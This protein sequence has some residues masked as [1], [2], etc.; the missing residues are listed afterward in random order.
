MYRKGYLLIKTA[1]LGSFFE[2]HI[3]SRTQLLANT[4]SAD[5]VARQMEPV[6]TER[7]P[8]SWL[9]PAPPSRVRSAGPGPPELASPAKGN[10]ASSNAPLRSTTP[11]PSLSAGRPS[12]R[13]VPRPPLSGDDSASNLSNSSPR[14]RPSP[15]SHT[16]FTHHSAPQRSS[17]NSPARNGPKTTPPP[18]PQSLRNGTVLRAWTKIFEV[19]DFAAGV[20]SSS[21]VNWSRE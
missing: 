9:I 15:A 21:C 20:K 5:K 19:D 17:H 6:R 12:R 16:P 13:V 8:V 14:G 11:S 3:P 1:A 7:G 18:S 2:H 10:A 4:T